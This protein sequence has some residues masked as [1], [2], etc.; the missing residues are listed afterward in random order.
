MSEKSHLIIKIV[1]LILSGFLIS[2]LRFKIIK[3]AKNY[4][5]P[6]ADF[7]AV[8]QTLLSSLTSYLFLKKNRIDN[9]RLIHGIRYIGYI[10]FFTQIAT[11][12]T[13]IALTK[14][15]YGILLALETLNPI[16]TFLSGY[17]CFNM[18]YN[19]RKILASIS[20]TICV[21][22]NVIISS[23]S[24]SNIGETIVFDV[25][26]FIGIMFMIIS[27]S[28]SGVRTGIASN[29]RRI[30]TP[31]SHQS[32]FVVSTMQ[33]CI[34]LP[35]FYIFSSQQLASAL[36]V[37]STNKIALLHFTAF[38]ILNQVLNFLL[39]D[40]LTRYSQLLVSNVY[41]VMRITNILLTNIVFGKSITIAQ[42][43]LYLIIIMLFAHEY[44]TT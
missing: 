29:Y 5:F 37:L 38:N 40:M 2:R 1:I 30:Y 44:I 32:L 9:R 21:L 22:I 19:K 25:N 42:I 12:T 27:L 28:S 3:E 31:T 26:F 20:I 23:D 16:F 24:F 41:S 18:K 39:F 34:Q 43:F 10:G 14:L 7:L 35:Y 15:N 8:S 33:L 4:D 13:S 11:F 36:N 17:L 6:H